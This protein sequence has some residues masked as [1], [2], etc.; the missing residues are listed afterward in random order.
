MKN[1]NDVKRNDKCNEVNEKYHEYIDDEK[2]KNMMDKMIDIRTIRH[3][4]TYYAGNKETNAIYKK[5]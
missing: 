1:K 3:I 4:E 2:I 5:S